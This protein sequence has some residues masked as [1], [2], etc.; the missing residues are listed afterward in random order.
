MIFALKLCLELL[1]LLISGVFTSEFDYPIECLVL[2]GISEYA[3][4][5][6][7]S[8]EKWRL[9]SSVMAASVVVKILSY[10]GILQ[11]WDHYQGNI[12]EHCLLTA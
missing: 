11:K 4:S 7:C 12:S 2:K 1:T 9:F 5:T 6:V 8:S 10:P 3:D